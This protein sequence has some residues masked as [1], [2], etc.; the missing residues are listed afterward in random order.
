MKQ[1]AVPVWGREC[2]GLF[3]RLL[4][5]GGIDVDEVTR[6][7]A[8]GAW[9]RRSEGGGGDFGLVLGAGSERPGL[10]AVFGVATVVRWRSLKEH[11]HVPCED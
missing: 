4:D 6:L 1:P 3:A 11:H 9:E 8:Y 7:L 2:V 5:L 10:L